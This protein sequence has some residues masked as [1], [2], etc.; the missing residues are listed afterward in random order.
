MSMVGELGRMRWF[1]TLEERRKMKSGCRL[2]SRVRTLEKE[3]AE[4]AQA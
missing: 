4:R 2:V 3:L 1:N